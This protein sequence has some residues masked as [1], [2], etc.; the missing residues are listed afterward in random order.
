LQNLTYTTEIHRASPTSPRGIMPLFVKF[1]PVNCMVENFSVDLRKLGWLPKGHLTGT[2][3]EKME[4]KWGYYI[5]TI[6]NLWFSGVLG[7]I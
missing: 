7:E 4:E 5:E 2:G 3:R 6:T 1:V